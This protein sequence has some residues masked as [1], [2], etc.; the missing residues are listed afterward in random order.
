V[1]LT[2]LEGG[3]KSTLLRQSAVQV[4]SGIHPFTL[5]EIDPVRVLL[6]DCENGRRHVR[7]KLRP[8]RD[9]AGDRYR[10]GYL[11]VKVETGGLDLLRDEDRGT[12]GRMVEHHEPDLLVLGPIYKR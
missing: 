8:L 5:D 1:I 3:G 6:V 7:R 2:A 4:A 10:S 9:E 12:L 11:R